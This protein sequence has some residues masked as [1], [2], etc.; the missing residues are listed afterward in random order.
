MKIIERMPCLY[1]TEKDL[2]DRLHGTICRY[3]EKP[4][5]VTVEGT[6]LLY[7]RDII[8][9]KVVHKVPPN[10][11][12]FDTSSPELGYFNLILPETKAVMRVV[13]AERRPRRQYRQG[14]CST[15][16]SFSTLDGKNTRDHWLIPG[17]PDST[18]MGYPGF[19]EMLENDYPMLDKAFDILN[20][21]FIPTNI[22]N[23]KT[24]I[25]EE[26]LVPVESLAI[27]K[28][29]AIQRTD[30]GVYQIWYKMDNVGWTT[31]ESRVVRVPSGEMGWIVSKYLSQFS[32]KID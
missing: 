14:I 20:D 10:D 8:T 13:Y 11:P 19:I 15:N 6:E 27:S 22:Q 18:W 32:W 23:H 24:G 7:L 2:H 28:D 4:Y 1:S 17:Y 16:L 26:Q 3:K 25:M 29:T 21:R 9:N 12:D 5:S 31:P 30:S